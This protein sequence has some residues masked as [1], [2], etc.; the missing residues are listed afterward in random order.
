MMSAPSCSMSRLVSLFAL[1]ALSF[2]HPTPTSLIGWP[3]IWAPVQPL[4]GLFGSTGFPPAYC[5]IAAQT[6]ARAELSTEPNAPWQSDITATLIVLAAF[7][8]AVAA[9]AANAAPNR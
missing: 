3:L 4:R 9:E 6:P 2:E 1:S 5:D 7:V 8:R